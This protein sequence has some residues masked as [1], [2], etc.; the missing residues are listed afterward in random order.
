MLVALAGFTQVNEGDVG[1]TDKLECLRCVERPTAPCDLLLRQPDF[2]VR[3]HRH[4]HHLRIWQFQV[5]HQRDVVVRRFHLQARIVAPLFADGGDGVAFIIVRGKDHG[6]VGQPQQFSE[7]RFILRAC[8][9]ILEIGAPGAA[10]QQRVAGEYPIAHHETVGIVGMAGGVEHVHAHTFDGELVAFGKPHRH[11][12]GFGILTHHR[13]AM[14]AVAQRT[15]A[16]DVVGVQVCI[17]GLDQSQIELGDQ[18]QVPID[19]LQ[20]RIDDQRLAAAAA[21]EQVGVR[22]GDAVE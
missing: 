16:R 12:V 4:V 19:L 1:S 14:C 8:I 18:L 5:R 2:H 22:A 20:D 15:Q 6:L 17:D 10:D 9:A 13:D 21:R 7:Q 11:H 3:G